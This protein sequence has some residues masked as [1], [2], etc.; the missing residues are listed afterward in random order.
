MSYSCLS[1]IAFTSFCDPQGFWNVV[2]EGLHGCSMAKVFVATL[3]SAKTLSGVFQNSFLFLWKWWKGKLKSFA[4][5][6]RSQFSPFLKI[7][8][9]VCV[10]KSSTMGIA[11]GTSKINYMDPRITV[12]WCKRTE[13]LYFGTLHSIRLP[14][15]STVRMRFSVSICWCIWWKFKEVPVAYSPTT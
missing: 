2:G 7:R 6:L 14:H 13:V 5:S 3:S 12:A 1:W 9:F 4:M 10:F 15:Q 11:L 8:Y